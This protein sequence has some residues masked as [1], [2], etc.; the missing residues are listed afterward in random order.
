LPPIGM[1][2]GCARGDD[3]VRMEGRWDEDIFP[4]GLDP[5]ARLIDLARDGVDAEVLYPT[6][7]MQ[8]YP[9][10]DPD[11]RWAL[12]RAYNTWLADRFCARHPQRFKGVAML[13]PDDVDRAITE[14][15]RVAELGLA[16][17][18]LPLFSGEENPY[19]HPRFDR[20]WSAAIAHD[21]PVSLHA[22][23]TRDPGRRWENTTPTDAILTPVGIQRVLLDM[24]LHGLFD[25]FPDLRVVSVENEA[26]WA[27][28]LLERADHFWQ[29][30]RKMTDRWGDTQFCASPPSEAFRRN[31]RLTF[32]RDRA[33]IRALELT[34]PEMLMWSSDFP[35]H[36]STWPE[37]RIVIEHHFH[38]QPADVRHMLVFGN[39]ASL[40]GFSS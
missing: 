21:M 2:A 5:D 33:A 16:G 23:T 14:L 27:G 3:E 26:G 12:F 37:S 36:V 17:V 20:L 28:S 34:G 9:V 22:S 31:V 25:R 4:S 11:F 7:G 10:S 18:M 6:V 38:D 1:L 40:Y 24:V 15:E 13:D 35:H 29:R 32:M 19:Y 39:V 8:L 30:N